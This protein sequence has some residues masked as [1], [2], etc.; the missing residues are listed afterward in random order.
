MCIVNCR[1]NVETAI[2]TEPYPFLFT[3][4]CCYIIGVFLNIMTHTYFM[5]G[6]AVAH[7]LRHYATN[8]KVAGSIPDGVIE[9]CQ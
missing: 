5:R 8:R 2:P 6:D 1:P 7:W 3:L 4:C 9:I